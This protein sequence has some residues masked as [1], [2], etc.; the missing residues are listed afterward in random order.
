MNGCCLIDGD[1]KGR[2]NGSN[3]ILIEKRELLQDNPLSVGFME[4]TTPA[5]AGI[6]DFDIQKRLT[7]NGNVMEVIGSSRRTRQKASNSILI[8]AC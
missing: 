4:Q 6:Y 5:V 8:K 7:T 3:Q 2:G 1:A